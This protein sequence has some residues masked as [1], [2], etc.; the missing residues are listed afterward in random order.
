MSVALAGGGVCGAHTHEASDRNG[1][2]PKDG[3]VEPQADLATDVI[4]VFVAR[5]HPP[6]SHLQ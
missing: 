3:P 4:A 6:I 5:D 2:A 1:G